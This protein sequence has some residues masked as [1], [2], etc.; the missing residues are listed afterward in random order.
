MTVTTV[1]LP[2]HLIPAEKFEN[3]ERVLHDR[4]PADLTSVLAEHFGLDEQILTAVASGVCGTMFGDEPLRGMSAD[5]YAQLVTIVVS[6]IQ[7][8]YGAAHGQVWD[9][10]DVVL[11]DVFGP[12]ADVRASIHETWESLMD[13]YPDSLR[14]EVGVL[15]SARLAY[16]EKEVAS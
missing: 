2:G 3:I 8:A 13:A 7:H 14:A 15:N 5:Y 11:A 12:F 6:S 1:R 10:D 16:Y 4:S 9:A